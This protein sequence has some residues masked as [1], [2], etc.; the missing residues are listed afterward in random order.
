MKITKS[1]ANVLLLLAS[2]LW[3]SGFVV[4]KVALDANVSVGFINF[5]RGIL[6]AVLV[7]MFFHKK[8]FKMTFKEFTIGLIAG[9]LNFGGYMTQTIG[10]QYT[11]PSNNAFISST[12]VVMVP[13]IAWI[14]YRKKVQ[15]KS[16]ISILFCLLG[17]ALLTG[18]FNTAFTINIGDIYSL[19]CALFYAGSIV[20][21]SYGAKAADVSVV[22]FMLAAVQAIGG[23]VFFLWE[24]I[25]QLAAVNWS[26]AIVPLLY[27]GII[28]SFVGQTLQV[29]AQK[30]TAATTAGLIMMLE[31]VFG[32]VFSIAFGFDRFTVNLFWGGTL[33]TLS[34]I[35]ME[36]DFQQLLTKAHSRSKGIH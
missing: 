30:H 33:I 27:I 15:V 4:I 24:G 8:I 22:V 5:F 31:G 17:M 19:I 35:L 2:I 7:L 23:F 21:L 28:C 25:G 1:M 36:T 12:Y 10:I 11:T 9:L 16:F 14:I 34:L 18:I 13:F 6:F 26:V 32:S 20:Y 3:G 29:L